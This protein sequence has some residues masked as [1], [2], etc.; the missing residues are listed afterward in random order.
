MRSE[1]ATIDE[2]FVL[3]FAPPPV[4][5]IGN[6]GGFQMMVQDRRGR[7]LETLASATDDLA[8]TANQTPGLANVYTLFETN[9]P[10]LYL[11]VD[12]VRAQKLGVPISNVFEAL[13]IY[14]GSSFVN[15]FNFLGRT[16]R[17]TAQ[18]DAPFR[19]SP[20][21]LLRL[22]T[23]NRFGESVPLGSVATAEFRTAPSRVSRYNLYPAV[24]VSGESQPGTSTGEALERMEALS[25]ERLPDGLSFEWTGLAYQQQQ[26]GNTGLVA[27]ALA[28]LFVFLLLAAQ[29]ES[30]YLPL[31]V[32]LIVPM[33]LLSAM[34][35]VWVAGLDNNLLVQTGL[36]VLV[37]LA[38]KNAI[39]IVEFARQD[40]AR[41]SDRFA[42]AINAARLR[43]RPILMTSFAFIL[44]VVPLMLASGPGAE[45]RHA[46]GVAV[47]S[48]M[49]GVTLFGLLFTP[50]FY[51]LCSRLRRSPDRPV[52]AAAAQD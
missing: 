30:W 23:Q 28:V 52:A 1:L 14:F 34:F 20:E 49:L 9:T 16:F 11:D 44:G 8:R 24:A 19:Q 48:G 31:S 47:F 50:V 13:E 21:D 41:G 26:A 51:V 43:L 39:L 45:M 42:A 3:V 5:G 4:R 2:A 7:G 38:A 12:R 33:C 15:D 10:Q 37:G 18:A 36:L 32:V 6:A 27:F 46:L 40:E 22:R 29:Y 25:A 17:V 35:G